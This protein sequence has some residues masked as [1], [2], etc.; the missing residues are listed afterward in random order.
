MLSELVTKRN[1]NRFGNLFKKKTANSAAATANE[2][3]VVS[4]CVK[5]FVVSKV[6]LDVEII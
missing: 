1:E 6:V 2:V 4:T 5:P 3:Q